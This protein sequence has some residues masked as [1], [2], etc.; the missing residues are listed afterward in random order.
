MVLQNPVLLENR[1]WVKKMRGSRKQ[2]KIEKVLPYVLTRRHFGG[3][4]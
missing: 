4:H 3:K 2:S 1:G